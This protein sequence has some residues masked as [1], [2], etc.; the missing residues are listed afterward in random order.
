MLAVQKLK[1]AK[2]WF[3]VRSLTEGIRSREETGRRKKM[4]EEGEEEKKDH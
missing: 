3:G 2:D 4:G 1:V